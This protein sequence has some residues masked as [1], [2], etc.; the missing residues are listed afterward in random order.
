MALGHGVPSSRL[1][2]RRGGVGGKPGGADKLGSGARETG[3]RGKPDS[4]GADWVE[5]GELLGGK[6][7]IFGTRLSVEWLLGRLAA[8]DD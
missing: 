5:A 1:I 8:G 4:D 3:W 7:T 6:P 2:P